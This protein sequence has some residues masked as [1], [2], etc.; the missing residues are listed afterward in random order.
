MAESSQASLE[1]VATKPIATLA[2]AVASLNP[3]LGAVDDE[4]ADAVDLR[5]ASESIGL[6]DR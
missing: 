6:L 3:V 2:T 4:A 1:R 5:L